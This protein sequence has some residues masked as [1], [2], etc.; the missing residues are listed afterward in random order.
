[1]A[2]PNESTICKPR[3]Q[4]SFPIPIGFVN[5]QQSL[6]AVHMPKKAC[7]LATLEVGCRC[8]YQPT[9][10]RRQS[11]LWILQPGGDSFLW[12]TG[13]KHL[14]AK[15]IIREG[16]WLIEVASQFEFVE[17]KFL[18]P[19]TAC[20]ACRTKCQERSIVFGIQLEIVITN[21]LDKYR[22]F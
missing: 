13:S 12:S 3:C 21:K 5:S 18:G 17:E 14:R 20:P 8:K 9:Y 11:V 4:S 7:K 10:V 2:S 22:T 16:T 19:L 15:E 1:M 6:Q